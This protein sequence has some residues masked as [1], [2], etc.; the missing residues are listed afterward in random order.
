M[1]TIQKIHHELTNSGFC[2]LPSAEYYK[3]IEMLTYLG[4]PVKLTDVK[5]KKNSTWLLNQAQAFPMHTDDPSIDIVAWYCISQDSDFGETILLDTRNIFNEM[6][7]KFLRELNNLNIRVQQS[8]TQVPILI[9]NNPL[10]IYFAPWNINYDNLSYN[11]KI[12]LNYLENK[13][14]NQK[15]INL[16]LKEQEILI[17]NN[18]FMLHGRNAIPQQSSRYLIRAYIRK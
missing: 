8:S 3:F 17:L 1:L 4:K 15:T 12:A 10:K 18:H 6:P 9:N 16:R 14:T 5:I 13:I 2:Y 7:S 11:Q